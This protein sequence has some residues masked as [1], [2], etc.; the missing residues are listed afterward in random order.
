MLV[1]QKKI[2]GLVFCFFFHLFGF[3][4]S[5]SSESGKASQWFTSKI[6][7]MGKYGSPSVY[8][9]LLPFHSHPG[10]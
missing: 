8:F 6:L 1:G 2:I 3:N 7:S 4:N 5:T 10:Y 9:Q